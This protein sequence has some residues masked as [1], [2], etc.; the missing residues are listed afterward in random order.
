MGICGTRIKGKCN[1]VI[2]PNYRLI[3]SG[4][5]DGRHGDAFIMHQNIAAFAAEI[6]QVNERIL[7]IS[8]K[9]KNTNISIM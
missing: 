1:M 2:Y 6:N 4:E 3:G 5:E 9:F 7:G 8:I